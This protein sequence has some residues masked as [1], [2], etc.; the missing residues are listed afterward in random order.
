[1][2]LN[3]W[4]ASA[5]LVMPMFGVWLTAQDQGTNH[6]PQAQDKPS[7]VAPSQPDDQI[8]TSATAQSP[9]TPEQTRKSMQDH[10]RACDQSLNQARDQARSLSHDAREL[11]PNIDALQ[12]QHQQLKEKLVQLGET[13]AQLLGDFSDDQQKLVSDHSQ[14]MKEIHSRIQTHLK[15]IDQEF[16]GSSLN[17]GTV[18][19]E[20]KATEREMKSYRKELQ[21]TGKALDLL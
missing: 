18:A 6:P 13:R 15:L 14:S 2:K 1:M 16:T 20:A 17:L 7:V 9:Q 19:D 3:L 5:W 10:F 12:Q 4:T 21:Q 8:V 11:P